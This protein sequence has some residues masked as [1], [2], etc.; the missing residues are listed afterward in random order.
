VNSR[1]DLEAALDNG[2]YEFSLSRQ[3]HSEIRDLLKPVFRFV[4]LF[5]G[6]TSDV[7]SLVSP[8]ISCAV[9]NPHP[10]CPSQKFKASKTTFS[11]IAVLFNVS[12]FMYVLKF[13]SAYWQL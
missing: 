11:A 4:D 10:C 1:A 13:M 12:S 8:H 3:Q 5:L 6:V 9:E 2:I 7:A